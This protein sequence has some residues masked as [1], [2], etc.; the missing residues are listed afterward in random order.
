MLVCSVSLRPPR[1]AIAADL[2]EAGG[3]ED[4]FGSGQVVFATLVDD[5]ASVGE[6]VDAYLG[7][8]I[9]EAASANDAPDAAFAGSYNGIITEAL[10][11]SD[12]PDAALGSSTTW[13]PSDKT[14]NVVLSGGNLIATT[15]STSDAVRATTAIALGT[16]VYFE[17]TVAS[18]ATNNTGGG[19]LQTGV[20]MNLYP[21]SGTAGVILYTG[22]GQVYVN[23][24]PSGSPLGA[25]TSGGVLCFAVDLVNN[26]LWVRLNNGN[27][28]ASG[29]ADPSTNTGGLNISG[30]FAA[31]TASPAAALATTGVTVTANFGA[32]FTYTK[33]SGFSTLP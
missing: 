20:G 32:A 4:D 9:A 33:P 16:K 2:L 25:Y 5:P 28:N 15:T 24:S 10:T 29:S 23:G 13:N 18:G 31:T 14:A 22:T 12:T 3:A 7:S 19:L 8:V 26:Q 27:W 11:A 1:R 6:I 21:G 17:L 30:L